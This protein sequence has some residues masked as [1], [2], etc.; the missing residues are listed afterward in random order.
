MIHIAEFLPPTPSP[1][2]KLAKQAGVDWAV[3][4]LP[5]DDVASFR[6]GSLRPDAAWDYLPLLRLKQR[7]ESAGFQLAVIESRPPLNKAKRG[8]PGCDEE[9]A[10]VCTLL[11]NMGKLG[12]PV[13]CYEWMTDFNW[14]RTST[15]TLSRGGLADLVEALGSGHHAGHL[16][17]AEIFR[18]DAVRADGNAILRHVLGSKDRSRTLAARAA[19]QCG[20]DARLVRA[21]L[22]GLAAVTMAGLAVRA[23]SSL[24][25]IL[26]RTPPLG[27]FSRG[28]PHTDLADILRRRCGAGPY[29]PRALPRVVRRAVARAA[30]FQPRGLLRWY[31]QFLARPALAPVRSLAQRM[32]M[33]R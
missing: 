10:T 28:S 9:I 25:E 2:W 1:L 11:E 33:A 20:L 27:R 19:R 16:D 12:V 15:N 13:W 22:P 7:Y 18:D 14:L 31:V 4:G 23:K 3:G 24:G 17:K 8:L 6:D 29:S 30:G 32:F 21:M 26:Q 5:F